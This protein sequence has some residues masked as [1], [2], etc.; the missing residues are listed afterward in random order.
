[1]KICT[2]LDLDLADYMVFKILGKSVQ[3]DP[4]PLTYNCIYTLCLIWLPP[5]LGFMPPLLDL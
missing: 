4:P 5:S 3:L 1:M 2:L